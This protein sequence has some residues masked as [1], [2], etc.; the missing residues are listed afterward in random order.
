MPEEKG[1]TG[2]KKKFNF[3]GFSSKYRL[4]AFAILNCGRIN[5]FIDYPENEKDRQFGV[6]RLK[7]GRKPGELLFLNYCDELNL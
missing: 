3:F 4:E 2:Y 5:F 6:N 7:A 1:Y